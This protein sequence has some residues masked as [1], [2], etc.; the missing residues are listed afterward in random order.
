MTTVDGATM[1]LHA[2][3]RRTPSQAGRVP[4]LQ[5]SRT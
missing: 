4:S 3:A 1:C 5:T 2:F